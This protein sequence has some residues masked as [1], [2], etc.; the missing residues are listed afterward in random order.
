MDVLGPPTKTIAFS[1][2]SMTIW[3]LPPIF[4]T[5][6]T[7]Y[8]SGEL[9]E[10]IDSHV[11]D[12]FN[13]YDAIVTIHEWAG[14][15]DHD[16]VARKILQQLTRDVSAKQREIVVYL[17]KGDTLVKKITIATAETITRFRNIPIEIIREMAEFEKR[18]HQLVGC[19]R[20]ERI[21]SMQSLSDTPPPPR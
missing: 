14:I 2:A 7:G 3:S 21:A 20:P 10:A 9:A 19:Y 16:P 11:K 6:V 5:Q 4:A 13:R 17:G 1:N 18:L 15:T 8:A 12:H